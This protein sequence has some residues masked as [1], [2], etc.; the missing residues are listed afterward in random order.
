MYNRAVKPILMV[1]AVVLGSC[2]TTKHDQTVCPEYRDLR[3]A[4]GPDCTFDKARGCRV[5]VC[6]DINGPGPE[7]SGANE[8]QRNATPP[9]TGPDQDQP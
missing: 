5:C 7:A 4:A 2:A 3:C 6:S 1:L 8:Q 9:E